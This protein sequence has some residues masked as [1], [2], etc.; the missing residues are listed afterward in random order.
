MYQLPSLSFG[1]YLN[2]RM[3]NVIK[4]K[5]VCQIKHFYVTILKRTRKKKNVLL[6]HYL[7]AVACINY[8]PKCV[9]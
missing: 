8:Q 6:N 5:K 1:T 9:N 7:S 4:P 3:W 2:D